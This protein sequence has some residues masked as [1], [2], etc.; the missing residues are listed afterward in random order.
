ML[1]EEFFRM[2]LKEKKGSVCI[3]QGQTKIH[4]IKRQKAKHT[5]HQ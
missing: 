5:E 1:K 2:T 3:H 4:A